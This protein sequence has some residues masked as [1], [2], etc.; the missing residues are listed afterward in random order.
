MSDVKT[1]AHARGLGAA[2]RPRRPGRETT[3]LA[4]EIYERDIRRQV[5][6]DHH[7][8]YMANSVDIRNRPSLTIFGRQRSVYGHSDRALL[9]PG[10]S[11]LDTGH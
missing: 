5:E 9:T 3:R 4:K 7:G 2:G 6:V 11:G 10:C 1:P 8:E